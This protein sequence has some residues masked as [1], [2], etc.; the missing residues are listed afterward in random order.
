MN[1]GRLI[2]REIL[3]RK[4]SFL[5]GVLL[6]LIAVFCLLGSL[7]LLRGFDRETDRI[8]GAMEKATAEE[9]KKL[10]DQ[11]RISMKGLGFNIFIYPENQKMS[12]VFEQGFASETMPEAYVT[13]LAESK[14]VTINHLLPRL[15]QRMKWEEKDRS[16][17]L[18][19]IRG[20][21]P[22][23]HKDPKKPLIAA[24]PR[25]QQVV[26]HELHK[27]FDLKA[28]DT[29]TFQG[30]PFTIQK[31][32][33]ERGN[34]DDITV[35]MH[36]ADA[37]TLLEKPGQISSIL[38]LECNCASIDR[39]GEIRAELS[40]ILPGAQIIEKQSEA[41]ARA[42]ARNI[43]KATAEKELAQVQEQR[44]R[45]R[46]LMET[47]ASI[48]VPL[49]ML[50][51]AAGIASLITINVRNRW[52]EIGTL[53]ALGFKGK[54]ILILIVGK[55]LM[56]GIVGTGIAIALVFGLG[57]LS[58]SN[59][60]AWLPSLSSPDFVRPEEWLAIAVV[61]PILAAAAAWLPALIAS[62]KHPSE[63]LRSD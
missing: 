47:F 32:H 8:T 53:R 29:V 31:H 12:E 16:I 7:V 18:I 20:E 60:P 10:E 4:G 49:I 56:M 28:G 37:Q 35:W 11:I 54:Q 27:A 14:I 58:L 2:I 38:A 42:E 57:L 30:R 52:T 36:L 5:A 19:G 21:V 13:R 39:L 63:V 55:A 50:I 25:G 59:F 15:A 44:K 22:F 17:M 9:M 34:I 48:L 43:A 61:T 62:Q 1:I 46:D 41:L 24:V 40:Q 33:S 45:L 26:G 51:S 3:H 6:V 23:A